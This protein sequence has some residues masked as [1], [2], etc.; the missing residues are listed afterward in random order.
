VIDANLDL[1]GLVPGVAVLIALGLALRPAP[2]GRS[3]RPG[4]QTRATE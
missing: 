4:T 1:I 3:R 2:A